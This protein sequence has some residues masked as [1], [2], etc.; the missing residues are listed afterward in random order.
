MIP[1][2]IRVTVT[3]DKDL[4]AYTVC[5]RREGERTGTVK[6]CRNFTNRFKDNGLPPDVLTEVQKKLQV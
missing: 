4:C 5:W 6:I 2:L 3:L 1:S